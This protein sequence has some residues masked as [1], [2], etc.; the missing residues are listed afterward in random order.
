MKEML[1]ALKISIHSIR[2]VCKHLSEKDISRVK[3]AK[4]TSNQF[5]TWKNAKQPSTEKANKNCS[6]I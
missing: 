1:A 4:V 6:H 5:T 2:T 3:L